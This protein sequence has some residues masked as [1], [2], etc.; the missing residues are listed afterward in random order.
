MAENEDRK[1]NPKIQM[2]RKKQENYF[3]TTKHFTLQKPQ[4]VNLL[5]G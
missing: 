1:S 5:P 3:R 2:L 4:R